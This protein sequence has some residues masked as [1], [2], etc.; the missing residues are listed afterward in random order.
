MKEKMG[1]KRTGYAPGD[2][3]AARST[4][5]KQSK[6]AFIVV[7]TSEDGYVL[8]H[9]AN[10]PAGETLMFE[11]SELVPAVHCIRRKKERTT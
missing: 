10:A 5:D 1:N 8:V 6:E 9:R 4:G 2:A 11:Q 3:V 7:S